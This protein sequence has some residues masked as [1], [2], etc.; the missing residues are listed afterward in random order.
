MQKMSMISFT[1][2][3]ILFTNLGELNDVV[4]ISTKI[5]VCDMG[6]VTKLSWPF[7]VFLWLRQSRAGQT[8]CYL[9]CW[10]SLSI[11]HHGWSVTGESDLQLRER[12]PQV[13]P[14]QVLSKL[15]PS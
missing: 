13:R 2:F 7:L 8:I 9:P 10:T 3:A 15:L 14:C 6:L 4:Y 1:M 12:G 5:Q 11:Q